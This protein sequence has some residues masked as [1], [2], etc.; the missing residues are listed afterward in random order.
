MTHDEPTRVE[1]PV[2]GIRWWTVACWMALTALVAAGLWTSSRGGGEGVALMAMG[3]TLWLMTA[4]VAVAA[5]EKDGWT[6]ALASG[7]M[8]DTSGI[9]LWI[10][11]ARECG[12]GFVDVVGP[13]CVWGGMWAIAIAVV[14][15]R[16]RLGRCVA[17]VSLCGVWMV[18]ATSIVWIG[19]WLDALGGERV[20]VVTTVMAANPVN[21]VLMG[22]VEK[23]GVVWQNMGVMY[24]LSEMGDTVNPRWVSPWVVVGCYLAAAALIWGI[25]HCVRCV[26]PRSRG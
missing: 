11:A 5:G 14:R 3:L 20:D 24:G 18:L 9:V 15:G 1:S 17:A 13:W 25:R 26:V 21:A 8:V 22:L 23:T 10:F 12:A 7:V 2:L 4:G 6:A 16:T 19:G